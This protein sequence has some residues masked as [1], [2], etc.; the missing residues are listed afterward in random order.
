[1]SR[2]T[3]LH[4]TLLKGH[5]ECGR[6]LVDAGAVG[7][8]LAKNVSVASPAMLCQSRQLPSSFRLLVPSPGDI[9]AKGRDGFA[10]LPLLRAAREGDLSEATRL[11]EGGVGASA[12]AARSTAATALARQVSLAERCTALSLVAENGHAAVIDVLAAA[13]ADV[14]HRSGVTPDAA[15]GTTKQPPLV[16]AGN[17]GHLEAARSLLRAGARVDAANSHGF[18]ALGW[19]ACFGD[20]EMIN[21]L[22][23]AGA[24][25]NLGLT[26]VNKSG[27]MP[28]MT[29][30]MMAAMFGHPTACARL[31]AAG[32]NVHAR[33]PGLGATAIHFAATGGKGYGA[34][35]SAV[36]ALVAHGADVEARF[37]LFP[38]FV[39]LTPLMT[40]AF[41]GNAAEAEAL[42]A[43][44]ARAGERSG[45]GLLGWNLTALET[46]RKFDREAAVAVLE[47]A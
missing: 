22:V 15:Y 12:D 26:R 7:H 29:P 28:G 30:L 27:G 25:V 45:R 47:D 34:A 35:E 13:G 21:A 37:S 43:C 24:P 23:S 46:A 5:A 41:L 40:A 39:N 11:L 1:M 4:A 31:L 32:A 36:P 9:E 14:D 17:G 10:S 20:V 44:G 42:L 6:A 3:L 2:N 38:V 18:T 16:L 19:A 33:V 8:P